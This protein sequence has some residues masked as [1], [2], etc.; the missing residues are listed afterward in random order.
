[1]RIFIAKKGMAAQY[2]QHSQSKK[3]KMKRIFKRR[4]T[5]SFFSFPREIFTQKNYLDTPLYP[6]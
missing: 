4:K 5:Q 2:D 6:Q 1:M 3:K